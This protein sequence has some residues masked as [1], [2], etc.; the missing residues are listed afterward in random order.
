MKYQQEKFNI[1]DKNEYVDESQNKPKEIVFSTDSVVNELFTDDQIS[2]YIQIKSINYASISTS[3]YD[4][5][6]LIEE[7]ILNDDFFN[8]KYEYLTVDFISMFNNLIATR[9]IDNV[10]GIM[11]IIN[12]NGKSL[13]FNILEEDARLVKIFLGESLAGNISAKTSIDLYAFDLNYKI[14]NV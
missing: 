5:S 13:N 14:I 3:I 2:Q 6:F 10:F 1:I 7:E 9:R 12:K 11:C 8:A 4:Y